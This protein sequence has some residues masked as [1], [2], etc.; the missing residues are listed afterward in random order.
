MDTLRSRRVLLGVMLLLYTIFAGGTVHAEPSRGGMVGI[1]FLGNIGGFSYTPKFSTVADTTT[2]N[3]AMTAV[4][5]SPN[6]NMKSFDG[7]GIAINM[8]GN[9]GANFFIDVDVAW[10]YRND[11]QNNT[12]NNNINYRDPHLYNKVLSGAIDIG[13]SSAGQGYFGWTVSVG[14][15]VA[16]DTVDGQYPVLVNLNVP[17]TENDPSSAVKYSYVDGKSELF[18]TDSQFTFYFGQVRAGIE[19]KPIKSK[20]SPRLAVQYRGIYSQSINV[21]RD[22][23]SNLDVEFPT[24]PATGKNGTTAPPEAQKVLV[25]ANTK[26]PF[27]PLSKYYLQ[28]QTF[29]TNIIEIGIK[30]PMG[31]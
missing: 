29:R 5:E 30:I 3:S 14:F 2:L 25:E 26:G 8:I 11:Y 22:E 4:P 10:Q 7:L 24:T 15:G 16:S 9:I 31:V 23:V 19:F 17:V 13:Y 6:A 21:Q 28:G 18:Y 27:V 20:D 1:F 12:N